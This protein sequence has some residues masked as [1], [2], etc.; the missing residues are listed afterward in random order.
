MTIWSQQQTPNKSRFPS[1]RARICL[2]ICNDLSHSRQ[3]P[4]QARGLWHL[5][6]FM[7][8]CFRNEFLLNYKFYSLFRIFL[9]NMIL[10]MFQNHF[11]VYFWPTMNPVYK[12][13]QRLIAISLIVIVGIHSLNSLFYTHS[14]KM[15]DGT[16]V[17]H[18]HPFSKASDTAP[19]KS[20]EHS[21]EELTFLANLIYF[22]PTLIFN[23]DGITL[24]GE[25]SYEKFLHRICTNISFHTPSLRAPPFQF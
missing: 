6:L 14:H 8:L 16:I 23:V 5:R 24:I 4:G 3:T 9:N 19:F 15:A 21:Q 10:I 7:A 12:I 22:V 2:A 25:Q 13:S 18:A 11:H 17:T 20:H 1:P